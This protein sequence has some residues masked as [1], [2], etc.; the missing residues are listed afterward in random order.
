MR[1]ILNTHSKMYR[2]ESPSLWGSMPEYYC[3]LM[4]ILNSSKLIPIKELFINFY[5][6]ESPKLP[7]FEDY[8]IF[9]SLKKRKKGSPIQHMK[10]LCFA[11]VGL[12]Q[13]G[14]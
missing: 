5:F 10:I 6:V 13:K 2:I 3:F 1:K 8:I 4:N 12:T 9:H 11:F 7:S 14:R